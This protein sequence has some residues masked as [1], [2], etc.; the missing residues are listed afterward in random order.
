MHMKGI[1]AFTCDCVFEEHSG[2]QSSGSFNKKSLCC[3]CKSLID[4]RF[5]SWGREHK[6]W[7]FMQS[8]FIYRV[9]SISD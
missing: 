7:I 4:N 9:N 1:L 2:Q 6:F 3:D 8:S 5:F